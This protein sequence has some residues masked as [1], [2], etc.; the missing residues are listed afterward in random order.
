VPV[1]YD[2]TLNEAYVNRLQIHNAD[3]DESIQ[4]FFVAALDDGQSFN[5]LNAHDLVI[6]QL[7]HDA[8]TV[9]VEIQRNEPDLDADGFGETV[10]CDESDGTVY[11]AAPEICDGI[12]NDCNGAVDETVELDADLDAVCDALDNC[13]GV[14][15]SAQAD[16]DADGVGDACD[17]DPDDPT[18]AE[19][20]APVGEL[21]FHTA[22]DF[23]WSL[24]RDD[25]G[26]AVTF[27][28]LRSTDPGEFG[29]PY[30]VVRD[31]ADLFGSDPIR[32]V[33]IY[34]YL[35]RV[36]RPCGDHL[37]LGIDE[38]RRTGGVCRTARLPSKKRK[39]AS[40]AQSETLPALSTARTR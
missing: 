28:V 9:T 10:D 23:S 36:E 17:C 35:V 15:N 38:Q 18:E 7:S 39:A 11:P 3:V 13:A 12:D 22:D 29:L 14:A 6:T 37:G 31:S 34:Y 30:C 8:T 33:S 16:S 21:R 2:E 1:G 19:A 24:P 4:T 40:G 27:D 20:I 5:D 32:P 25:P 26:A